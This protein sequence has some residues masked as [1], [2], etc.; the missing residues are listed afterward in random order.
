M[1]RYAL[2][3]MALFSTLVTAQP[4][5]H[6]QA[7]EKGKMVS[8]KLLQT[9]GGNLQEH[10]G[11]KGVLGGVSFCSQNGL[12]LTHKVAQE[13]NTTLKRVS[14]H[15][16]NPQNAASEEESAILVRWNHLQKAKK[17]L[18]DYEMVIQGDGGYRYYQPIVIKN[19]LCLQC[20][21][22]N[23]K[24]EVAKVIDALYPEDNAKRYA[25]GDLRGMVVIGI[26]KE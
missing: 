2:G 26:P 12:V 4:L 20:H 6:D 23:I 5:S 25:L 9:L 18:P 13:T 19:P 16:R 17:P 24:P 7:V 11:R 3:A 1:I 21:G 14:V 22:T 10:I 15:N 8:G